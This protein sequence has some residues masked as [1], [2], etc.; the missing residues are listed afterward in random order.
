LSVHIY[1]SVLACA[2]H[3]CD[4]GDLDGI[5]DDEEPRSD[6]TDTV[7]YHR[8]FDG[9]DLCSLTVDQSWWRRSS[10][11]ELRGR[12]VIVRFCIFVLDRS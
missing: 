2:R 5:P 6:V 12:I 8:T 9:N 3:P 10:A 1:L 4:H 7:P 11:R